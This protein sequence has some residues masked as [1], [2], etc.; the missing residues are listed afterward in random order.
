MLTL[1]PGLYDPVAGY[2]VRLED[3]CY[4]GPEGL[5]NLTP[6]PLEWD[7]TAWS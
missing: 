5:E 1:E 4:L 3:M 2:G 6:L 7:P